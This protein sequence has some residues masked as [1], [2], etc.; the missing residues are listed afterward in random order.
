M[1]KQHYCERRYYWISV[2][3]FQLHKLWYQHEFSFYPLH[4]GFY[5]SIAIKKKANGF[6]FWFVFIFLDNIQENDVA[7]NNLNNFNGTESALNNSA[8]NVRDK[9]S[10][11]INLVS[12]IPSIDDYHSK[13]LSLLGFYQRTYII[14]NI[15]CCR[16]FHGNLFVYGWYT[17]SIQTK[18]QERR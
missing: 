3:G 12:V 13:G 9:Y 15:N 7:V 4:L 1:E 11:C 8:M 2:D 18:A 16:Y 5:T 17:A 10:K 14:F 6:F